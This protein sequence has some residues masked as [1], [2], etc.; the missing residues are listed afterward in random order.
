M[1]VVG[2]SLGSREGYDDGS[3]VGSEEGFDKGIE[4]GN[5][6]GIIDIVGTGVRH[7]S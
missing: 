7:T 3:T 1:R 6:E 2:D 5:T 4:E